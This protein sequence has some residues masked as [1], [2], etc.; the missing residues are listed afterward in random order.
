MVG[1]QDSFHRY[2]DCDMVYF[3]FCGNSTVE[4]EFGIY[5]M[6]PGEVILIPG[7]ISHRSIGRNDSLRYFCL[8]HEAVDYVM[9]EDQYTSQTTFVVKR[10]GGPN[11]MAPQEAQATPKG[12]VIEKMHF[13]DDGPED[14]TLVERD[15][16][17]VGRSRGATTRRAGKRRAQ[18]SGFRPFHCDRRQGPR[19][20]R[21]PAADG[22]G[23]YEDSHLQ[24]AGR[25]V[26][27]SSGACAARR[28]ASSSA[29]TR[30]TCPSSKMSKSLPER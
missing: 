18:A 23:Q 14:Q 21:H 17:S 10:I 24:H 11:W 6:E 7:G 9:G 4:T 16:E 3:Q 22:I 1:T 28:C 30:S 15:Y 25:A 20:R 5:E 29:A 13:W 8:S 26:C 2:V 27:I 19:R 12:R